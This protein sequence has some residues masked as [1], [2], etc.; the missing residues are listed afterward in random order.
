MNNTPGQRAWMCLLCGWVYY[1]T[2]GLPD[3][4]IPPRHPLGKH[5]HHLAMPHLRSHQRRL[6][7]GTTL[8]APNEM[9]FEVVGSLQDCWGL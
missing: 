3:E 8:K 7:H 9:I 4:G 5:P 6:H 1:E 2:L